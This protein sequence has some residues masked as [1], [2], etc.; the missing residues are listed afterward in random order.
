MTAAATTAAS[1]AGMTAAATTAAT[2]TAA[3]TTGAGIAR[4]RGNGGDGQEQCCDE[5]CEMP[6]HGGDLIGLVGLLEVIPV[7]VP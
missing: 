4:R 2:T 3:A 6:S 1:T 7:P 5:Y